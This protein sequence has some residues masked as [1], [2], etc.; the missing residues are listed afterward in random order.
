LGHVVQATPIQ[1]IQ[2]AFFLMIVI[3]KTRDT[4]GCTTLGIPVWEQSFVFYLHEPI[5][6]LFSIWHILLIQFQLHLSNDF[7]MIH[8]EHRQY[9]GQRKVKKGG[10]TFPEGARNGGIGQHVKY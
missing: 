9:S 4:W 2:D 1:P 5:S 6:L 8:L 10:P 3:K 7:W